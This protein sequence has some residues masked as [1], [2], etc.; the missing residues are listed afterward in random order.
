MKFDDSV[1]ELLNTDQVAKI[2]GLKSHTIAVGRSEGS[3]DIPYIKINR[4][5]RYRKEEVEAYIKSR[6]VGRSLIDE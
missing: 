6:Q 3:L 1:P 4:S 5:V 2:L